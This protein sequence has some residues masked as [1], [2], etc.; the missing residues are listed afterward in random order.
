MADFTVIGTIQSFQYHFQAEFTKKIGLPAAKTGLS[1]ECVS[2]YNRADGRDKAT[3][4]AK[5][6]AGRRMADKS[7]RPDNIL[8]NDGDNLV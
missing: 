4:P 2:S 3:R 1:N 6:M 8:D 5:P 7:N